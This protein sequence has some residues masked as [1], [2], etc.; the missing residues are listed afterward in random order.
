MH[1]LS[2]S[3]PSVDQDSADGE[4]SADD[5]GAVSKIAAKSRSRPMDDWR[6]IVS[7]SAGNVS[8]SSVSKIA[9]GLWPASAALNCACPVSSGKRSALILCGA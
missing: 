7:S 2:G 6:K 3:L 9:L 4:D 1:P 5:D 8:V